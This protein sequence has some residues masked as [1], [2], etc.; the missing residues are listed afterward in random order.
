MTSWPRIGVGIAIL[1]NEKG[2]AR[3]VVVRRGKAPYRGLWS[4]PGGAVEWG[5]TLEDAARREVWEE[6]GLDIH[7]EK[8]LRFF[9]LINRDNHNIVANHFVL[10]T[11]Q[12]RVLGGA[13]CAADD[14]DEAA[15]VDAPTLARLTLTPGV[16]EL[17]DP[18]LASPIEEGG[19]AITGL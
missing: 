3:T 7:I 5:E 18:L 4:L 2:S 1:D 17:V 16:A 8:F 10:A 14:A 19:G 6:T 9:D 13:L 12:A 11:F 15:W